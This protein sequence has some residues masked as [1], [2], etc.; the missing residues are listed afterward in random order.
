MRY[1]N[2][3]FT[4]LFT[5][6]ADRIGSTLLAYTPRSNSHSKYLGVYCAMSSS[7]VDDDQL[8]VTALPESTSGL[9]KTT[10]GLQ[11]TVSGTDKTTPTS[12]RSTLLSPSIVV[13]ELHEDEP[14]PFCSCLL[15]TSPSPR[16]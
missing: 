9:E 1:I 15:Y 11:E 8:P 4:Y 12:D 13:M 3:D 16:D 5:L 7:E 6:R 10:S 14:P 2:L